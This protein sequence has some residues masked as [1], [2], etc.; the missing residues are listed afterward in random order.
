MND[1]IKYFTDIIL[2]DSNKDQVTVN[3]VSLPPPS[4]DEFLK[5]VEIV[6]KYGWTWATASGGRFKF[7]REDVI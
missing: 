2:S 5:I 7:V 4:T 3:V 6:G 1:K